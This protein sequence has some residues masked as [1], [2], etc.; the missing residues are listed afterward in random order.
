[1]THL[2]DFMLF[3]PLAPQ[4][5]RALGLPLAALGEFVFAYT[6][7]AGIAGLALGAT[8]H[9]FSRRKLLLIVYAGFAASLLLTV[10]AGSFAWLIAARV[11]AGACGGVLSSLVQATVADFVPLERRAA[12][13]G[14]VMTGHALASVIGVPLGLAVASAFD[15]RAAFALLLILVGP[16]MLGIRRHIPCVDRAQEHGV[17]AGGARMPGLRE[18]AALAPAFVL[19]FAISGSAYALGAY[20]APYWVGNVGVSEG[21]LPLVFLASGA[22]SLQTSPRI[23][24]LAD[25]HGR[26]RVFLWAVLASVIT[27]ALASRSESLPLWLAVVLGAAFFITVYGRWIPTLALLSEWPPASLRGGFMM[28]NGVVTQLSMGAGALFAGWMIVFDD[29]GRLSGFARVGE[30]AILISLLSIGVAWGLS[31]RISARR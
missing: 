7:S 19:T 10:L 12:A 21:Q 20:F 25:R 29:S 30:I 9:R 1:M 6:A 17:T 23:G 27:I 4:L 18:L 2:V 24:R 5:L 22:L 14:T 28:L 31:R 16:L 26:F 11:L 8:I 13:L 15:W 3:M